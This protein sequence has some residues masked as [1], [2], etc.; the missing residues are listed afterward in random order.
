MFR[1]LLS[2]TKMSAKLEHL[3]GD[4]EKIRR[5]VEKPIPHFGM[6]D[7]VSAFMGALVMGL[8]FMF[9]GLLFSV[10][11]ALTTAHLVMIVIATIVVLTGEI[12]WIGYQH[13]EERRKRPFGQFWLKRIITFYSA[14]LAV[15]AGLAFLYGLDQFVMSGESISK[16]IIAVSFPCAVGAALADLLRQY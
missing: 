6:Y 9:K 8:T 3:A 1:L 15:S 12:Y 4:V 16:I 11:M 10:S 5:A 7:V 14:A 13:A 2:T